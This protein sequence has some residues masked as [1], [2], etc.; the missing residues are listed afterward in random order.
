MDT[1]IEFTG[2]FIKREQGDG[3]MAYL[4]EIPSVATEGDTV[5]EAAK[6]LMEQLPDVWKIQMEIANEQRI[7]NGEDDEHFLT[8][9]FPFVPAV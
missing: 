8:K 3:F 9:K 7:I 5:E 1:A 2:I 6:K 4:K